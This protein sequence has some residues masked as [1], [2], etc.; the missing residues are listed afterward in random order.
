[1]HFVICVAAS[2]I[3][4][5]NAVRFPNP[6]PFCFRV[7]LVVFAC[8]RIVK[9]TVLTVVEALRKPPLLLFILASISIILS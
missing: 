4:T 7:A 8:V 5:P 6:P 9:H 3:I 1:M 2:L